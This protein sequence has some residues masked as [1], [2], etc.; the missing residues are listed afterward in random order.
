MNHIENCHLACYSDTSFANLSN[1][2]SQGGMLISLKGLDGKQ[3]P[4]YWQTR[5]IRPVVESTLAAETLTLLNCAEAAVYIASIINDF[6]KIQK[7][8][9]VFMLITGVWLMLSIR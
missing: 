4:I 2:G 8:R 6:I 3:C 7:L 5:R 9:S 1:G